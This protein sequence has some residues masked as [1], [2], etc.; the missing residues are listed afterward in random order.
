MAEPLGSRTLV[1]SFLGLWKWTDQ[2]HQ[3]RVSQ[4]Q[5]S[6]EVEELV[7]PRGLAPPV[8][9]TAPGKGFCV[10]RTWW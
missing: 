5:T 4:A 6:T 8:Q 7:L 1:L 2:E 3:H 9:G 10:E